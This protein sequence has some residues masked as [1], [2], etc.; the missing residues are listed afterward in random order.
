M[1]VWQSQ[2]PA[3]TS[4]L[5][6]VDGWAAFAAALLVFMATPA[7]TE[8]SRIP[9]RVSMVSSLIFSDWE[10]VYLRIMRAGRAHAARAK[11]RPRPEMPSTMCRSHG[12]DG[13]TSFPALNGT[14]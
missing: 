3:G 6:A 4:K 1:W 7:A 14:L 12:D 9:R 11:V 13:P 8:A 2:A 5:P 10:A